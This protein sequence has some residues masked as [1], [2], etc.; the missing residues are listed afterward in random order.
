VEHHLKKAARMADHVYRVDGGSILRLLEEP[1]PGLA[2]AP[3]A[4]TR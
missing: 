3:V 4:V 2:D 1:P